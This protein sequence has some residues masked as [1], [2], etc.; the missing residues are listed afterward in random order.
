[1]KQICRN[2]TRLIVEYPHAIH[3]ALAVGIEAGLRLWIHAIETR[4]RG[5]KKKRR[6]TRVRETGNHS[7]LRK[8]EACIK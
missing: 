2:E 5:G 3:E 4:R 6:Q 7:W 8:G 1:M